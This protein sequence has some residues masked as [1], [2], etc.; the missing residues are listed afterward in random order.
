VDSLVLHEDR[1]V[2]IAGVLS[3]WFFLVIHFVT[4]RFLKPEHLFKGITGVFALGFLFCMFLCASLIGIAPERIGLSALSLMIYAL[5]SFVYVLCVF[6]PYETSIRMRLVRELSKSKTGM[7]ISELTSNYNTGII[8]DNRLKRLLG[9]GDLVKEQEL[10]RVKKEHN[11]FFIIDAVAQKL[12][13]F[14]N[15][16]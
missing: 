4:F 7:S 5:A 3:F 6:G 1:I 13:A 14:I 9:G 2:V 10:F 12:D 16:R 15:L 8:I 11:A